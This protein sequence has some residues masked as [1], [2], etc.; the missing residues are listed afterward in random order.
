MQLS[1]KNQTTEIHHRIFFHLCSCWTGFLPPCRQKSDSAGANQACGAEQ[2][3]GWLICCNLTAEIAQ[4]FSGP[5]RDTH[6]QESA[7]VPFVCQSAWGPCCCFPDCMESMENTVFVFQSGSAR[8]KTAQRVL[9]TAEEVT[10]SSLPVTHCVF[11][12]DGKNS[13]LLHTMRGWTLAN[14]TNWFCTGALLLGGTGSD[15][16]VICCE[17]FIVQMS[18][19]LHFEMYASNKKN[20]FWFPFLALSSVL[21]HKYFYWLLWLLE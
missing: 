6:C 14:K 15:F 20:K 21:L 17:V 3:N 13:K 7:L 12:A 10:Q 5:N 19:V 1:E 9:G 18:Q 16:F 4:R 11:L 8:Y 2:D